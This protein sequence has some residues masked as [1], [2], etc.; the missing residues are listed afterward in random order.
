MTY[1][2][3]L[4]MYDILKDKYGRNAYKR[5]S[6][7][8]EEAK[9]IHKKDWLKNKTPNG[10]HEQSWRA[11]KGK[12]LEKLIIHII[13][14]EVESLGLK[15]IE[16]NALDKTKNANLSKELSIVKRNLLVDYGEF[17]HHLP[18]VDIIIYRPYDFKVI[19][20]FLARLPY[21]K[22]L[23]KQDIGK[24]NLLLIKQQSI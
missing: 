12:N 5:V 6:D 4:R 8:L 13:K 3:L 16:G 24:L 22:E 18:D 14:E 10:D 21:E 20:L 7:L 9:K 17:G 11:F 19:A 2:D 15:I 1:K 23:P